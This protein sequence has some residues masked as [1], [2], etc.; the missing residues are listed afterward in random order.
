MGPHEVLIAMISKL[1]QCGTGV[2]QGVR[3]RLFA[4]EAWLCDL[5]QLP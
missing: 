3:A 2:K 4:F 5:S 1:R